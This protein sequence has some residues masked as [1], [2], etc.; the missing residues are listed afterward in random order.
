MMRAIRLGPLRLATLVLVLAGL[1]C[2]TIVPV[3]ATTAPPVP[4][5]TLVALG[6][7]LADMLTATA[8]AAQVSATPLPTFTPSPIPSLT[9]S[10][11]SPPALSLEAILII[12]PAS[13]PVVSPVQIQGQADPTF[14]Q[15]LVIQITDANGNILTTVPVQIGAD[16]G[17]RG[18]F[19]AEVEFSVD[20]DQLGRISVFSTSARDGGLIHFSSVE[21]TL[22]KSGA[23]NRIGQI[24]TG[25]RL[26]IFEPA[27]QAI[28]SG[29]IVRLS[30]YSAPVFENQLGVV[31]CG[32][33][34]AGEPDVLC[35]TTDNV[36]AR[37]TAMVDAPDI[38]QPGPFTAELPYTVS[39]STHARLAVY[40]ASARD[41]GLIHFSSV[42]VTLSP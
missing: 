1:A 3:P 30:G 22:S 16:I 2:A 28:I 40:S 32:E 9:P 21:V 31:I 14:E 34:G 25:E 15:T 8:R 6:T 37:G 12:V 35:G 20:A 18:P 23:P 4:D 11:T 10:P 39:A 13:G 5:P 27:P 41:G 36:L 29:G 38:G 19:N 42:E 7:Q 17:Q 26:A 24:L 33:G